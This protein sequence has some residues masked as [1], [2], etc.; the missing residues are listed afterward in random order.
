MA[1]VIKHEHILRS[2]S[3]GGVSSNELFYHTLFLTK[4]TNQY[5]GFFST[6]NIDSTNDT[7]IRELVLNKTILYIRDNSIS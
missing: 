7:W 4:N 3:H 6:N 5:N 2:L 1:A